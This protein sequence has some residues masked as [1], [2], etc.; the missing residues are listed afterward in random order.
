M[1]LRD[2]QFYDLKH[3][4]YDSR[5]TGN[6][7]NVGHA[8]KLVIWVDIEDIFDGQSRAQKVSTGG[9]NDTLGLA[10]GSGSLHNI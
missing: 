6:P 2:V 4:Q 10:S 5:V 1:Y 9:V 3:A 7:A 8:G